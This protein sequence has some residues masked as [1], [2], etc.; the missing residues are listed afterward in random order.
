MTLD[1]LR[2]LLGLPE[3]L[4]G[5]IEDT[6][7][8]G[9]I[10]AL[11]AARAAAPD[12]RVVV[13]SEHTHSSTAK[14]AR[15]L[16]LE[17]RPMPAD[18]A[19]AMRADALDLTRRLCGRRDRRHDVVDR[20][21]SRR[22]RSPTGLPPRASGSTS[23]PPTPARPPSARSCGTTSPAGSAPTRSA[24]TRTSGCFTPMDCSAFF[25]RRPD[26]LRARVQPRAR[27]TCASTRTSSASASTPRRSAAASGRSSSGRCCAASGARACRRSSASTCG[28]PRCSRGGSRPS[29][30]WEVCA[31]RHVLARLLPHDGQRRGERGD[32]ATRQ[33]ERRDLPLAH[34]ARRP[35]RP[36]PRDRQRAD[37]RGG[38]PARVG[39][40]PPRG[41]GA[42]AR[43]GPGP[44]RT[45][46][47]PRRRS[48][49]HPRAR[50]GRC[51]S[52]R[53]PLVVLTTSGRKETDMAASSDRKWWA[54]A[55]DRVVQFMSSS[56]SR[57]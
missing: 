9:L 56:T 22:R 5:H 43:R 12:R 49:R 21:R 45:G 40:A 27:S 32:H 25:C 44:R 35:L 29:P 26:D 38:R 54:L 15:L 47:K 7:S 42:V 57:S 24:S 13:C 34:E 19:F 31:P 48:L 46:R 18:D 11:A 14:A 10:T 50:G 53:R 36:P 28:W 33:R 8:S 2:Q 3:A 52:R 16:E 4:H 30:G 1:W 23:T 41:R 20:G 17:L 6:A 55:S 51:R 37:D 39:R